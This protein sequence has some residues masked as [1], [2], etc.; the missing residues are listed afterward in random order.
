M[1]ATSFIGDNLARRSAS[2]TR[3]LAFEVEDH[4]VR[5]HLQHLTKMIVAVN[6][7]AL[8]Q[9]AVFR[10]KP[11]AIENLAP[12]AQHQAGQVDEFVRQA[13]DAV[14]Q[15][16]QDANRLLSKTGEQ[17]LHIIGGQAFPA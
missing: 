1:P 9:R 6:P 8:A 12:P 17:A 16:V 4:I 3:R 5:F 11:E 10:R 2:R 13:S 14:F 15:Q 7:N